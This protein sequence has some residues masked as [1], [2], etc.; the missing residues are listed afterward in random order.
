MR[1][2]HVEV[3]VEEASMEAAL[4]ALLPKI[5][6]SVP[7]AFHSFQGKHAL[8]QRLPQRLRTYRRTLQPDWLV[9]VVIDRDRDDC[10]QLKERMEREAA[11]VGLSTR[12]TNPGG[13]FAI[14]NRI[15]VEE[16]EAW[17][18]GDWQAVLT[19]Y[20]RVPAGIAS[21]APYRDPDAITGGTWEAF[22]RVMSE[23]GYFRAGLPKIEV[24]QKIAPNMDPMRNTSRSFQVLRNAL[25]E[26]A[27][28]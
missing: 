17:Y 19:A 12:S 5:V 20:P 8:L 10:R 2:S 24:A 9:L 11:L 18:F 1:P 25:I 26:L 16:L 21:R 23:A 13:P 27:G 22:Q 7:C 15:A 14:I 4:R 28:V 3:L 6:G